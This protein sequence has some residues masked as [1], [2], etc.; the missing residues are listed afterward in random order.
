MKM[1]K[2]RYVSFM[3]VIVL[4]FFILPVNVFADVVNTAFDNTGLH[5]YAPDG[6]VSPIM[7]ECTVDDFMYASLAEY[8]GELPIVPLYTIGTDSLGRQTY[9][10]TFAD[11]IQS[12]DL[13]A[14]QYL[15]EVWGAS[16]G[17]AGQSLGGRG[18]FSS[19]E[20]KLATDTTL[21]I[22]VGGQGQPRGIGTG[23]F[24][25]GGTV[26]SAA[27]QL[28]DQAHHAGGGGGGATHIST[29]TGIL[30]DLQ[31]FRGDI[32]I[33]A[34]GGGGG[35]GSTPVPG[36][37][38]GGLEG[39]A[40]GIPGTGGTQSAGGVALGLGTSGTF[41]WGGGSPHLFGGG[42][43]GLF[44]GSSGFTGPN[45]LI[46]N[47]GGG[48]SGY[49][50]GLTNGIT[51]A[52]NL[53]MPN[54][55]P[56][57]TNMVGNYGNGM[58]RITLLYIPIPT[59]TIT[60]DIQGQG[61]II[62]AYMYSG[63]TRKNEILPGYDVKM[64]Q[65]IRFYATPIFYTASSSASSGTSLNVT[66]T[67]SYDA[68]TG[69]NIINLPATSASQ[70]ELI[71]VATNITQ[72]IDLIF[73]FNYQHF[74]TFKNI[75]PH[76]LG[77]T[78]A[79]T[80]DDG[81]AILNLPTT[82]AWINHGETITFTAT[83]TNKYWAICADKWSI[84][85]TTFELPVCYQFR[86]AIINAPTDVKAGFVYTRE[87]DTGLE[88]TS[89]NLSWDISGFGNAQ[90][91]K[92]ENNTRISEVNNG[93]LV[94][95]G[96]QVRL[97]ASPG[98]RYSF[99]GWVTTDL[100]LHDYLTNPLVFDMPCH[101]T[102]ITANFSL[103]RPDTPTDQDQQPTPDMGGTPLPTQQTTAEAAITLAPRPTS[104]VEEPISNEI[105]NE[106]AEGEP[107]EE[108]PTIHIH[109]RF[110]QGRGQNMFWPDADMT[111]AEATQMLYNIFSDT[112]IGT[113]THI[114]E[115]TDIRTD[116][117]YSHAI[118]SMASEGFVTGYHDGS[119]RP[120]TSITRAEFVAM[121]TRMV[122]TPSNYSGF[123]FLDVPGYHWAYAYIKQAA[124]SGWIIGFDGL[125]F[126]PDGNLTRAQAVTMINRVL[127][128]IADTAFIR[129]NVLSVW[130]YDIY[131]HWAYYDIL[132]ASNT[133][134]YI[135]LENSITEIWLDTN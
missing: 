51:I 116:A 126:I 2:N 109:Q 86:I 124:G 44:G 60:W 99:A 68:V 67:G 27:G 22:G 107:F 10:F 1:T 104:I 84:S 18:G 73:T 128:R 79:M 96:V 135:R 56:I 50:G 105:G 61:G 15:L 31:N 35:D 11:A 64:G 49:I 25:G 122:G 125:H 5:F 101:G 46:D 17:D 82:G 115:F 72:D 8:K 75:T 47:S 29:R 13:P 100:T 131:K 63:D 30:G 83:P 87:D 76:G 48:G 41:G 3:L 52:G 78:L 114:I 14:G 106:V 108:E 102:S 40:N 12:I 94:T 45:G 121:V 134:Y 85:T 38:G 39:G 66:R 132:E 133:H 129:E 54:T 77:G 80:R 90:A 91:F 118:L 95:V 34:G 74:T 110:V 57:L 119:F 28:P 120:N 43:G 7:V 112:K 37:V 88:C 20:I 69:H 70:E 53:P 89:N 81:T 26:A 33:V 42:G 111:R 98:Y 92:Y 23:G 24:N 62:R 4:V 127:G 65:N 59:V 6:T 32:L 19:G 58:A 16:G 55:D 117:W 130:F 71:G 21:F 93:S 97:F 36:G 113:G 103:S 9:T 123:R